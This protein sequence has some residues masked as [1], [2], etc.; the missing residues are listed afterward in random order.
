M[1]ILRRIG[2]SQQSA[3]EC[4]QTGTNYKP[5]QYSYKYKMILNLSFKPKHS[6]CEKKV[7]ITKFHYQH[8]TV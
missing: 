6:S 2:L 3:L 4:L 1:C 5:F 7:H 8:V